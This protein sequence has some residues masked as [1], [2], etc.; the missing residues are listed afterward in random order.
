MKPLS[1]STF[2]QIAGD[3]AFARGLKLYNQGRVSELKI[4]GTRITATLDGQTPYQVNLNH[5]AK[6]FEGSCE[7]PASDRFDFCKHCVAVSLAYY[8]QTQANQEI[9]EQT[10]DN[11]LSTFLSTLTKPELI[12][13]LV[14]LID[15]DEA[16]KDHWVL[17]AE[18]AGGGL[19]VAEIRKRITKAIPYKASGLWRY[20][21]VA[22]YFSNAFS[23]LS[24]LADAIENQLPNSAFKLVVYALQRIEKTL[25]SID[26]TND[27]RRDTE[28]LLSGI[29][30]R[31]LA[32]PHFALKSKVSELTDLILDPA[33][34]YDVVNI[35]Y[36][37]LEYIGEKGFDEICKTIDKAWQM[38]E[39]PDERFGDEYHYYAYLE[40][41]L[42][43]Q[44][45]DKNDRERELQILER[46]ALHVERCLELVYLCIDYQQ[47]QRAEKWLRFSEQLKR[48]N[49]H[50]LYDVE[51]AQIALWLATDQND[52]ALDALWSRFEETE[53]RADLDKVLK[54]VGKDNEVWLDNAI[55]LLG[56]RIEP[57]DK[58]AKTQQRV[59]TLACLY[60]DHRRV[61][62]AK[63]LHRVFPLRA[64]ALQ[65][66]LNHTQINKDTIPLVQECV[67]QMLQHA[68]QNV[69]EDTI[70]T[71][72]KHFDSCA[73][74][75]LEE[76]LAMVLRVYEKPENKRRTNFIKLLKSTFR[77]LF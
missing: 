10:S 56:S 77:Q 14:K 32:N 4:D 55:K 68:Y 13:E 76:Y 3:Q 29:F 72:E 36:G 59:E 18:L 43:E 44:A 49:V 16:V 28:E 67:E 65:Y 42:V 26:D 23:D 66:L 34:R 58:Q 35:P 38:L 21:D 2:K 12:Q 52:Q 45:Q 70:E 63:Q 15:Q 33:F 64:D 39:L 61:E 30:N 54:A 25:K 71:L 24:L 62:E 40:N 5:T 60:I 75:S 31:I 50:E 41:I 73:T 69:Y 51:S 1:E 11:R 53:A 37:Q 20:K 7:C 6:L 46:G 27:Y 48:L 57:T 17:K 47:P 19:S 22:E 8:Y 74:D 9:A